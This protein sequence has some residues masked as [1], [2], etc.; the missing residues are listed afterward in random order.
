MALEHPAGVSL[1]DAREQGGGE[2]KGDRRQTAGK[3][4]GSAH[5]R[6]GE[7]DGRGGGG[8]GGGMG[9]GG[10]TSRKKSVPYRGTAV[11]VEG[12]GQGEEG[13][14]DGARNKVAAGRVGHRVSLRSSKQQVRM[15]HLHTI[16]FCFLFFL[17]ETR[18]VL[19]C[20]CSEIQ[21]Y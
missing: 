11:A 8:A 14:A 16:F 2:E 12:E 3:K 21:Q 4:R 19:F 5:R 15:H 18:V 7:E 1:T 9:D 13:R 20:C 6:D 10:G 17:R